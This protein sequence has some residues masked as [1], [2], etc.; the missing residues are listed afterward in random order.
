MTRFVDLPRIRGDQLGKELPPRYLA[1]AWLR[2]GLGDKAVENALDVPDSLL[3][4]LYYDILVYGPAAEVIAEI[5]ERHQEIGDSPDGDIWQIK[6]QELGQLMILQRSEED[7]WTR[8][9]A[10]TNW[11][12]DSQL[13]I[14]QGRLSS[15]IYSVPI[16]LEALGR[17]H[18]YIS[19]MEGIYWLVTGQYLFPEELVSDCAQV[20]TKAN[21][22]LDLLGLEPLSGHFNSL[23]GMKK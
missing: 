6:V 10:V 1:D 13:T 12:K 7:F 9:R 11:L 20:V 5:Y 2:M 4:T 19:G 14:L 3:V 17:R 8:R 15:L 16:E 18:C 22:V 23:A 21:E